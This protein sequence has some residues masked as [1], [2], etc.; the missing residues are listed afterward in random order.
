M[1][2]RD[3]GLLFVVVVIV[4][5]VDNDDPE[6]VGGALAAADKAA[7][8]GCF[9]VQDP[10]VLHLLVLVVLPLVHLFGLNFKGDGLDDIWP[11]IFLGAA[12]RWRI[13]CGNDLIH[14]VA[15]SLSGGRALPSEAG[16]SRSGSE[17]CRV[18]VGREEGAAGLDVNQGAATWTTV[19]L[20][21]DVV[22]TMAAVAEPPEN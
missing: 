21:L 14:E 12:A 6:V 4:A 13:V 9:Q 1:P 20:L 18:V 2:R 16:I 5:A 22:W 17:A 10:P 15:I 19:K 8:H 3:L 7:G 11:R